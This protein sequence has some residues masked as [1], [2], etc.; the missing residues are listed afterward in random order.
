MNDT[1]VITSDGITGAQAPSRPPYTNWFIFLFITCTVVFF[2]VK[3]YSNIDLYMKSDYDPMTRFTNVLVPFVVYITVIF[4]LQLTESTLN[5]N[6]KCTDNVGNNFTHAFLYCLWPWLFIFLVTVV[7]LIT[8][9]RLKKAFSDVIGYSSV[10]SYI[11]DVFSKLLYSSVETKNAID[12]TGSEKELFEKA[13]EAIM[14]LVEDKALFVN[15]IEPET[16]DKNWDILKP[17]MKN[18][19]A[20]LRKDLFNLVIWR[21]IIGEFC[22]Y[23]YTGI[24][25][26]YIVFYNVSI[27][28]CKKSLSQLKKE[29]STDVPP[30]NSGGEITQYSTF[31]PN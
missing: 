24:F 20:K 1:T 11:S 23:I 26:S 18:E 29:F 16:F 30:P 9:P 12:K 4:G 14:K 7:L 2:A 28:S 5:L 17:L 6:K 22:W 3:Y 13:G 31:D 10:A 8:F 27:K 25:V 15:Q 19:S 21:D